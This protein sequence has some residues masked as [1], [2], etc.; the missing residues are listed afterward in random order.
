MAGTRL[1]IELDRVPLWRENHVELRQ[2]SEDFAKYIYLPRLQSSS[3]LSKAV[4][5]GIS[6]I[7]WQGDAFAYADS[8]DEE[9]GRY[10]GLKAGQSVIVNIDSQSV[11]VKSEVATAQLERDRAE[12]EKDPDDDI[13]VDVVEVDVSPEPETT[14][15]PKSKRFYGSC[16]L[17][18]TRMTRDVGN[19]ADEVIQHLTSLLGA[20]VKVSI[21]IHA[22]IPAG[23]PDNIVRIVTEN[24]RTLR[25]DQYGFEDE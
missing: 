11:V 2:L 9:T 6:L 12:T 19:I 24:S 21:D 16:K 17:D 14:E 13:V 8:W 1:K 7:T 15:T 25:F 18:P 5:D 10:L 4:E 20:E 3:I 23:V 22:E